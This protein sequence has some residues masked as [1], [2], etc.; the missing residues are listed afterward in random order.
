MCF[1]KLIKA[2]ILKWIH[3]IVHL[4]ER[5]NE[6]SLLPNATQADSLVTLH[7]HAD[8]ESATVPLCVRLLQIAGPQNTFSAV[9]FNYPLQLLDLLLPVSPL[10]IAVSPLF[11]SLSFRFA[12]L[13]RSLISLPHC[14][15]SHHL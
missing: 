3:R 2:T 6:P 14:T 5:L 7:T 4:M 1:R 12:R 15:T 10:L 11:P 9:E 13:A 8:A